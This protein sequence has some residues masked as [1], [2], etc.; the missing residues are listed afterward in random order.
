MASN[1]FITSFGDLS[2]RRW[3]WPMNCRLTWGFAGWRWAWQAYRPS[4]GDMMVSSVKFL[5]GIC[6]AD[7]FYRKHECYYSIPLK[8]SH[9]AN[10]FKTWINRA[11]D[12][13][14]AMQMYA[15]YSSNSFL[16]YSCLVRV[17]SSL[18]KS[19]VQFHVLVIVLSREWLFLSILFWLW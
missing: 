17:T 13:L 6:L 10:C 5:Y 2:R 12:V 11:R 9:A 7:K 8:L 19:T 18:S 3:G 14:V 4:G 15:Y 1:K 16:S